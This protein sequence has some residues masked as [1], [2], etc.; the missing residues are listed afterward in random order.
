MGTVTRTYQEG[1]KEDEGDEVKVGKVAP[2]LTGVGVLIAGLI[3]ET[4]QHDL[5][6]GLPRGTPK[7]K[8]RAVRPTKEGPGQPEKGSQRSGRRC[9]PSLG[10]EPSGIRFAN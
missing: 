6:P 7:K 4:R 5:M 1:T 2:T 10:S 3:A 9:T 8:G